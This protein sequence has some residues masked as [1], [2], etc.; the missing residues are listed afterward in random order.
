MRF[1]GLLGLKKIECKCG[2]NRQNRTNFYQQFFFVC[3]TK[4]ESLSYKYNIA[5][6]F[7][8]IV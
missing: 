7:I 3:L 4:F 6:C 1:Y 2:I 8:D 5:F